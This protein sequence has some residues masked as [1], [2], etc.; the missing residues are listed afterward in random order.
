MFH[1]R[2]VRAHWSHNRRWLCISCTPCTG[3]LALRP[4]WCKR[5]QTVWAVIL[6][7]RVLLMSLVINVAGWNRSRS[8]DR[9]MYQSSAFGKLLGLLDRGAT[10]KFPVAGNWSRRRL[11]VPWLTLNILATFLTLLPADSMP[12]AWPLSKVCSLCIK[13]FI[14]KRNQ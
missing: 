1:L 11:I 3:S 10:L 9:R 5:F 13:T 8:V 4:D 2:C 6:R 7:F 14:H 12:M